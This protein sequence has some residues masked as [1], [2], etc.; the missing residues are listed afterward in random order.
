MAHKKA[1]GSRAHQG[2]HTR[3]KRRGVRR[4]DGQLVNV[5]TILVRQVGTKIKLGSNVGVGRDFTLFA[6]KRGTVKF[7]NGYV[8]VV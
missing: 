8:S 1:G 7:S 5:G 6:K 3:G 4:G 2:C